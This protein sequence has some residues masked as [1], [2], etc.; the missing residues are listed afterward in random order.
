MGESTERACFR[1][2]YGVERK[3]GCRSFRKKVGMSQKKPWT[4]LF[5]TS[6]KSG[7][8]RG[9]RLGL[10]LVIAAGVCKG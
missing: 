3:Y 6:M 8:N 5:G 9:D 2:S 1:L 10:S 4:G 7:K